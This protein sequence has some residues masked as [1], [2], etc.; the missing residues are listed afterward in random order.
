MLSKRVVIVLVIVAII[1]AVFSI[2]Y[3][4]LGTGEEISTN[5]PKSLGSGAGE[6]GI[7]ILPTIPEDKTTTGNENG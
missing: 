6:V 4:K 3:N 1:L 7:E 5:A 2:V